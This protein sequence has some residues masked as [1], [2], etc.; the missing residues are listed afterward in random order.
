MTMAAA[1]ENPT[2]NATNWSKANRV[3]SIDVISDLA[4]AETVWRGL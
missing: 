2:A 3:A 4:G 1:I